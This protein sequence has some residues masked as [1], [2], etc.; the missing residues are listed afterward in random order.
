MCWNLIYTNI[1]VILLVNLLTSTL[2]RNKK[3]KRPL[4]NNIDSARVAKDVSVT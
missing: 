3:K 2:E 4:Q 1:R